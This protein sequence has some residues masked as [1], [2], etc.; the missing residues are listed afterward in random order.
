ME[1]Y[2]ARVAE[3][4]EATDAALTAV[5]ADLAAGFSFT[6]MELRSDHVVAS[7]N[8]DVERPIASVGKLLLLLEVAEQLESDPSL[9]HRELSRASV[10]PVGDSGLWQHL[11][12]DELSVNDVVM[13][14]GAV[15]DNLA[16]NVL[17][18]LVSLSAVES[19]TASLGLRHTRLADIVRDRRGADDPPLLASGTTD[20]LAL[21]TAHLARGNHRPSA[22]VLH[23]ISFGMDLSMVG[24]AFGLD[25]LSHGVGPDRG[26]RIW[27]KTGT[28]AGVRADVGIVSRGERRLGYAA[29]GT[30]APRSEADRERDLVLEL[31][32]CLGTDLR[33]ILETP[34]GYS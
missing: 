26:L 33:R 34:G 18:Q 31:M 21:L 8:G 16:T 32:N 17:L 22:Q 24:S 6:V 30:W 2:R 10:E 14:V 4:F 23:W 15:S 25:P 13:L 29:V 12:S 20:E 7:Y 11:Q 1:S 9:G 5:A 27:S 3:H 19:R 28:D